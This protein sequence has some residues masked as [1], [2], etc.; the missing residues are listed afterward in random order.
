MELT[1]FYTD[2]NQFIHFGYEH[3][4]VLMVCLI[5]GIWFIYSGKFK[6]TPAERQKNAMRLAVVMMVLQLFKPAIRLVLGNYNHTTDLPFHLCSL[7][8]FALWFIYKAQHR[9]AWA[10][11]FFWIMAGTFQA[12]FT[13]TLTDVLPHYEALRYWGVHAGV[14]ILA[15]FGYFAMGWRLKAMD[16]IWSGL[17]MNATALIIYPYN[18]L[19]HSNYFFLNAKPP[20]TTLYSLLPAWPWYIL[21]LEGVL[22]VLFSIIYAIFQFTPIAVRYLLLWVRPPQLDR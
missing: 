6:W 17:A 1:S 4:Q 10:I 13:P 8:P 5:F 15:L 22:I 16:I 19:T 14:V 21:A 2:S 12:L 11:F 18:C 9:Q 3:I 20:G 7:M